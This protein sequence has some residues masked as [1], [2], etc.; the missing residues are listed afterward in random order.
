MSTQVFRS[1]IRYFASTRPD[2]WNATRTAQD[3]ASRKS[4]ER[5]ELMSFWLHDARRDDHPQCLLRLFNTRP[6]KTDVYFVTDLLAPYDLS[7]S[8]VVSI[9]K[10]RWRV[11]LFLSG[12]EVDLPAFSTRWRDPEIA[13]DGTESVDALAVDAA[14][15]RHAYVTRHQCDK[16]SVRAAVEHRRLLDV[17]RR[18]LTNANNRHLE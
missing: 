6:G 3:I 4:G 13:P 8:D 9:C 11:E 12:P 1:H 10:N 15:Y 16:A 7:D 18:A 5:D 17:F 14:F 2:K